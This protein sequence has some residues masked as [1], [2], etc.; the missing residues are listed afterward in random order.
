MWTLPTQVCGIP[1]ITWPQGLGAVAE[2]P[3][4][5]GWEWELLDKLWEQLE[6]SPGDLGVTSNAPMMWGTTL[7]NGVCLVGSKGELFLH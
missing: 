7:F 3:R 5:G 2:L 4:A 6:P 1:G